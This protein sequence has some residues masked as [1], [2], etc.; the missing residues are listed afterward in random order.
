MVPSGRG[1]H[2]FLVYDEGEHIHLNT[3]RGAPK[4]TL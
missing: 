1:L 2:E 3:K 4:L